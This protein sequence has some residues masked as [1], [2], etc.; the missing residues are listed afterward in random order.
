M[1]LR[2]PSLLL[3][4]T[5]V[6][7]I[8]KVLFLVERK[9]L[10]S[11]LG[12]T[13]HMAMAIIIYR[14]YVTVGERKVQSR[15]IPDLYPYVTLK[16]EQGKSKNDPSI[17]LWGV[18]IMDRKAPGTNEALHKPMEYTEQSFQNTCSVQNNPP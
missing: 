9:E 4:Q 5:K 1:L 10:L 3:S 2:L 14:G 11:L 7:K 17:L 18:N 15:Y 12:R 13:A 6:T 8:R 16:C